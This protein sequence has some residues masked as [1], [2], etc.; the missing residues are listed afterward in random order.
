MGYVEGVAT[1]DFHRN[2]GFAPLLMRQVANRIMAYE[3]GAL[4]PAD[5]T[6]YNRLGW[7]YWKGPLYARKE[8]YWHHVP[9]ETAMILKTPTTPK[10]NLESPISLEWREGEI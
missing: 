1:E 9:D 6:L 8:L 5:T 7:E 10:I 3:I 4:S 2:K